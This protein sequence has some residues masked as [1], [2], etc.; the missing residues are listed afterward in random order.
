MKEIQTNG[1]VQMVFK[2]YSDFFMY[3]SGIYTKSKNAKLPSNPSVPLYH[4]VKVVGWNKSSEG[5]PFW[6]AKNYFGSDWG[7]NGYFRIRMD[8]VHTEIG[9]YVYFAS[10]TY[11]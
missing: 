8:D 4:A 9:M 5:I 11:Q 2:V 3:K 6:I 10:V 7:E 1:P